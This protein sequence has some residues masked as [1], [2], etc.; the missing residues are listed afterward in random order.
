M[1]IYFIMAFFIFSAIMYHIE[2]FDMWQH[3]ENYSC[4]K[5]VNEPNLHNDKWHYYGHKNY[6]SQELCI[7]FLTNITLVI[8]GIILLGIVWII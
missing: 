5:C 6:A 1:I 4:D 2:L 3:P 8:A 7:S